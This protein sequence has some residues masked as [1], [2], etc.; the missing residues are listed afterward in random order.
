[1]IR[2]ITGQLEIILSSALLVIIINTSFFLSKHYNLQAQTH[3]F[4]FEHYTIA[5]GLSN[6]LINT[7]LQTR[8]GFIWFATMDGLNRFDG[9]R[10]VVYKHDPLV[11]NSLPENYIRSLFE[12][13][14]GTF[15]VGTWGGGLCK[16]DP[17]HESFLKIETG[18]EK[19]NYIQCIQE[20][21]D[22]NL[23]FGTLAGGLFKYNLVSNRIY[24]Y[25]SSTRSPIRL[26]NDNIT[27]IAVNKD[28]TL[29]IGTWGSGFSLF[30]EQKKVVKHIVRNSSKIPYS[31]N[32]IWF[33]Q[34]YVDNSILVSSDY[35]VDIYYPDKNL[36][37]HNLNLNLKIQ[38][39]LNSPIRQTFLDSK[40]RL[41]I[42]TYEYH[43]I[44]VIENH[45][46][47]HNQVYNVIREEDD[48]NSLSSNRVQWIYEDRKKNIWIGT[49][50][51]LNK[52]SATKPFVNYKY[53]PFRAGGLGGRV[54]SGIVNSKNK[55]LWIGLAGSGLDKIDLT[56]NTV[57]HYHHNP[58]DPNSLS[59]DDV[60]ALYE[61]KVGNIWVGTR[62][63]GLNCLNTKTNSFRRY[64]FTSENTDHVN[65]NWIHQVLET[66]DGEL[67]V[68][69]NAGLKLFDRKSQSLANYPSKNF[70]L[71]PKKYSAN[72]I[73]EDKS[74]ELWIGTW[75]DGLLRYNNKQ[76]KLI[77]YLPDRKSENSISSNKITCITE[78]S[79][80][81]IWVGTHSGGINKFDK[82]TQ[83]FFNYSIKQG[84]P[85]DV[86][87]GILEDDNGYLWIS[88]LNGLAR[89]D[90]KKE[91]FRTYDVSD[92]IVDNR[93]NW[94]ASLKDNLGKM[95]FGT[96]NG[97]ITFHPSSI[98]IDSQPPFV[99]L[100]SFKIF[101]KEAQLPQSLPSTKEIFLN[102]DQNFF[103]FEF[104]ALDLAPAYKHQFSYFLEGVDP[105]WVS[106]GSRSTAFYTDVPPGDYK[107]YFKAANMDEVWSS[108][109]IVD[110][111][112]RAAWWM[113]WWFKVLIILLL[114]AAGYFIYWFRLKQKLEIQNIRLSIANDLHDEIGS[115]LSSINVDSQLLMNNCSLDDTQ[116]E[117]TTFISKTAKETVETMRDIIWFINPN[118]D[119]SKDMI[120][121]MKET[122]AKLLA[123][124]NWTFHSDPNVRLEDFNLENRRNIYLIY[125]EALNNV[126]RHA[127]SQ[128]CFINL[129]M[130]DDKLELVVS[131]KGKGFD[132]KSIQENNG[133]R[134]IKRRAAMMNGSLIINSDSKNGTM[135]KLL[136]PINY[137]KF[138]I[139]KIFNLN[140][141]KIP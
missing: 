41:W 36:F 85:N 35:G 63:F 61:D 77:Q 138:K 108:A 126:V 11:N 91:K 106:S 79:N 70:D 16:Y 42:G 40:N 136:V 2:R 57:K 96:I 71:F 95:Y 28:N 17:L 60:T 56:T 124:T 123:G 90:T 33:I 88:T 14:D 111:H 84:L 18:F 54:I 127:E 107:F 116:K 73:L 133:L 25:N 140:I 67:L 112:I 68:G 9:Q 83:K 32:N 58:L 72:A 49:E 119:F 105:N 46:S 13:S 44:F 5:N 47:E 113:T 39:G 141:P 78:D 82:S 20:D 86:V 19:D 101:G 102:Y 92:G 93:F 81:F 6:N 23:W 99:V 7:I 62:N 52:L 51:G 27:T 65:L 117:L 109:A 55:F 59:E 12:S 75:L 87:F 69:T 74:G 89:F 121:K 115:N 103:S 137:Q 24:N 22:K 53:F 97:L 80:G 1:M 94:H 4:T 129:S 38:A 122:A 76:N 29:W 120:N 48:P 125:K 130:I 139:N 21:N 135:V 3:H 37:H 50:D 64:V 45:S 30:D 134:S 98:Q 8:D 66:K 132:V 131:D 114:L 100:T 34:K 26:L 118:N 128:S 43:G 104:T 31:N 110:I 10:F 15:W